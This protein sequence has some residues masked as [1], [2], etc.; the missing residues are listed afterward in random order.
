MLMVEPITA[1]TNSSLSLKK[2]KMAAYSV[3]FS[4]NLLFMIEKTIEA[5]TF[6]YGG[7]ERGALMYLEI[8]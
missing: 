5:S 8:H 2:S 4:E 1:L 7:R 3:V 6:A